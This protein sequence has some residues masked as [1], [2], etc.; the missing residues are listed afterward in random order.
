VETEDDFGV[1]GTP[2][3]H[4]E[5]LD[6]LGTEFVDRAWDVKS[7][8]RQMVTSSVY[9]QSYELRS[10]LAARDPQNRLL[11]RQSR[12][13]LDAVLTFDGRGG[14]VTC[15]RRLRG[16]TPLQSLTLANDLAFFECAEALAQRVLADEPESDFRRAETAFR[17][18]FSRQPTSTECQLLSRLVRA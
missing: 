7:L 13:R 11:A 17:L 8:H 6:W 14:N 2:P 4:P 12:L 3:S 1:Q 16:N 18:C 9:R 15:T 5:L 10:D